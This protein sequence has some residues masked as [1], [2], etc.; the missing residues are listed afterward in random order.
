[1]MGSPAVQHEADMVNDEIQ[2]RL[3]LLKPLVLGSAL[4]LAAAAGWCGGGKDGRLTYKYEWS[5]CQLCQRFF[6]NMLF[7][8]P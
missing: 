4:A 5:I 1:M 6:Q 7:I 2:R 3:P 8:F